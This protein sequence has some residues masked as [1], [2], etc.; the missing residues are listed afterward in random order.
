MHSHIVADDPGWPGTALRSGTLM[1]ERNLC[2]ALLVTCGFGMPHPY[3]GV[4]PVRLM[5]SSSHGV[6]ILRNRGSSTACSWD[7]NSLPNMGVSK[8]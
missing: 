7:V 8:I 3:S 2:V 1:N 5:R 6:N 4:P